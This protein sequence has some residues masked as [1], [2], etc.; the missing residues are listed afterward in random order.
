MKCRSWL[1]KMTV[2]CVF[3]QGL[4]KRVHR[5]DVEMVRRFVENQHV[6]VAQQQPRQTEP[7]ALAAGQHG[8]RLLDVRF[9]EQQG[10]GHFENLL[11]LLAEGG[12]LVKVVQNRLVL[13]QAGVDVLGVDADLAAIPPADFAR[14]AA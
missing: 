10:A 4:G 2:P 12:L 1:V 3:Q 5:I 7:G 6:V 14:R 8:D 13:R 11:I 9:P